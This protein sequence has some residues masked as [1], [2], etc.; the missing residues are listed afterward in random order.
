VQG[1][2]CLGL[3]LIA[4]AKEAFLLGL[5]DSNTAGKPRVEAFC[6]YNLAWG[7]LAR[8]LPSGSG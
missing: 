6:R 1:L 7:Q 3:G 8:Q 5:A 4:P 2:A